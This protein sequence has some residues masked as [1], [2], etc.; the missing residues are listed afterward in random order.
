MN[1]LIKSLIGRLISTACG[2][3]LLLPAVINKEH[4]TLL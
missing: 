1:W 3:Q 4:F 2:K